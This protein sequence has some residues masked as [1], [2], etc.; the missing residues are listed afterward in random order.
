MLS[1]SSYVTYTI[2]LLY[3]IKGLFDNVRNVQSI[4]F[5]HPSGVKIMCMQIIIT[6]HYIPDPDP[7]GYVSSFPLYN[8][9]T[10][11]VLPWNEMKQKQKH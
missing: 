7:D 8:N 9:T 3:Y 6:F 4:V 5:E 10:H 2:P 11:P 1:S